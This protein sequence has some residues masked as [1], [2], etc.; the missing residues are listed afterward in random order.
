MLGSIIG[1]VE[2]RFPMVR[3]RAARYALVVP[4]LALAGGPFGAV[5]AADDADTEPVE[6]ALPP[7]PG[8]PP[9]PDGLCARLDA[10]LDQDADSPERRK[11][12]ETHR[13]LRCPAHPAAAGSGQSHP[14]QQGANAE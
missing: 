14:P 3:R 12:V 9:R 5:A 8:T 10:L 11:A 7:L 1:L 2:H 6:A 13:L 4:L